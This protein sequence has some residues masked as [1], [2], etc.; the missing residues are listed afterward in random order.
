MNISEK[1]V[2]KH[3]ASAL[4]RVVDAMKDDIS[5]VPTELTEAGTREKQQD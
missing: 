1:T 4:A 3:L 5:D 2:E